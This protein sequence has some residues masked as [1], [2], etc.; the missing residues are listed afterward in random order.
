MTTFTYIHHDGSESTKSFVRF[1]QA[2]DDAEMLNNMYRK[3]YD[4]KVFGREILESKLIRYIK[5]KNSTFCM[6]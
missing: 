2:I 6:Y 5:G 4:Y 1:N 3:Q